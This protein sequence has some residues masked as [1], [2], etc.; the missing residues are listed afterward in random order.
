MAHK[1]A[2]RPQTHLVEFD[3]DRATRRVL[4]QKRTTSGAQSPLGDFAITDFS[5]NESL[6]EAIVADVTAKLS[7]FEE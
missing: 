1:K 6:E 2:H 7:R 3:M 4:G 5:R